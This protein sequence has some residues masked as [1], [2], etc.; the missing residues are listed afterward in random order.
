MSS[1]QILRIDYQDFF[2]RFGKLTDAITILLKKRHPTFDVYWRTEFA[3]P[4]A[5][6]FYDRLN[7]KIYGRKYLGGHRQIGMVSSYEIGKKTGRPHLHI[8]LERPNHLSK[9]QFHHLIEEVFKRMEWAYESIDLKTYRDAGFLRYMCKG[10]FE[11]I[12]YF[13]RTKGWKMYMGIDWMVLYVVLSE[14][15]LGSQSRLLLKNNWH[16]ST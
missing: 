10:D 8:V 4:T 14:L 5:H 9:S 16:R 12:I 7:K 1:I 6:W 15:G 2:G 13:E 11:K 3:I